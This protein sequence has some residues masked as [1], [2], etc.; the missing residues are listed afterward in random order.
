LAGLNDPRTIK[1][2]ITLKNSKQ[3]DWWDEIGEEERLEI[4]EGLVQANKGEVTPHSEVMAKYEKW[5]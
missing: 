3:V 5:L 4:K 2:F 1:E